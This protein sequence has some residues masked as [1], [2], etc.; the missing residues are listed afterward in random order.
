VTPSADT[1]DDAGLAQTSFR[2]GSGIGVQTA[3][4]TLAGLVPV[5]FIAHAVAAP[6]SKIVVVAGNAQSG[7]VGLKLPIP[8]Q[9][10]LTDA[11]DNPVAGV[12]VSFTV[13]SGGGAVAASRVDTDEAGLAQTEWTLGPTAGTQ[14]VLVGA[15]GLTPVTFQA[16]ATGGSPAAA[17][18]DAI[19]QEG[20]PSQPVGQWRLSVESR[21]ARRSGQARPVIN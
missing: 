17:R 10:R 14:S 7:P 8:L 5:S 15:G 4:A 6:A 21:S 20:E 2:L 18:A 11:F 1:T 3:S 19:P 16:T 13:I 9:V 12:T